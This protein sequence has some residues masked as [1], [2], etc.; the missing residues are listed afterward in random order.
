MQPIETFLELGKLLAGG[1][2]PSDVVS[3][4]VYDNEWFEKK[5]ITDAVVAIADRLL[6]PDILQRWISKYPKTVKNSR[7][8][9]IVMAGNIPFVGFFDL[10]CVLISGN[11]AVVKFSDKDR[12]LM[13]WI[14]A[15]IQKIDPSMKIERLKEDAPLDAVIA[16][17]SNNANRYF[18]SCYGNI[19]ALFRR[20]RTSVAVLD[21]KETDKEVADLW[22]DIFMYFGLGCRNVTHLFFPKGYD[23]NRV[24]SVWREKSY[25]IMHGGFINNY[26]QC[27]ALNLMKG[28]KFIDGGYFLLKEGEQALR[29]ISELTF[30]FYD[31]ETGI[32][33]WLDEH[34]DSLQ[35]VV[36][37]GSFFARTVAF[38]EAQYPLPW[39][40]PDGIDVMD[41]L[42][43]L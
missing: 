39:D 12:A 4:A 17:G 42:Q 11:K 23:I 19:P 15:Q 33:K 21:G 43:R 16:T 25:E 41:F 6:V 34:E 1:N 10:M 5:S 27:K 22:K 24:L 32:K 20:N 35:C 8:V 2:I 7:R 26:R 14:A 18:S 36:S 13:E 9:G 40:Y 37:H 3:H 31:N 30:S 28:D 38:G 29:N